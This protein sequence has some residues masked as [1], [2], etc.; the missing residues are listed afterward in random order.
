MNMHPYNLPNSKNLGLPNIK[1]LW[2]FDHYVLYWISITY[3]PIMQIRPDEIAT[4]KKTP[5]KLFYEGIKSDA[6]RKDFETKLKK[7]TYD[8]PSLIL[9]GDPEKISKQK[10]E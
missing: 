6:S 7:V 9:K 1:Y 8:Y 3:L 2:F 5:L 4:T 10:T